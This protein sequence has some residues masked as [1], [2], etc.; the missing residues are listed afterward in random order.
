MVS[1]HAS[2]AASVLTAGARAAPVRRGVFEEVGPGRRSRSGRHPPTAARLVQPPARRLQ[3]PV[4]RPA[5][6]HRHSRRR[7]RCTW[8]PC[9]PGDDPLHRPM[10]LQHRVDGCAQR[11]RVPMRPRPWPTTSDG[12]SG[13][14]RASSLPHTPG[15][16][17]RTATPTSARH[18]PDSTCVD[19]RKNAVPRGHRRHV[20]RRAAAPPATA[21][22][23]PV[24]GDSK[25]W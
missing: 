4:R 20:Q 3:T 17:A 2:A 11:Q 1:G 16:E 24:S 12:G 14:N 8:R 5:T 9:R 21:S 23:R 15:R 25:V 13:R 19:C 10:R 18:G 22:S 6:P 7:T